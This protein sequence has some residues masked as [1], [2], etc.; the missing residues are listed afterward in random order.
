MRRPLPE[1][2]TAR[3]RKALTQRW[4]HRLGDE[5]IEVAGWIDPRTVEISFVISSPDDSF[6]YSMEARADLAE[7][8][9]EPYEGKDLVLDFLDWYLGEY[10]ESGRELLLPMDW[11]PHEFGEHTVL[12]RGQVSNLKLERAADDLLEGRVTADELDPETGERK[13]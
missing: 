4:G 8:N 1:S 9:I 2:E 12:A 3:V 11:G 5:R 13:A 6:H 10:L 7:E